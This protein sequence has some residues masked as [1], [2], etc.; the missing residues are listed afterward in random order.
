[1]KF[2][3]ILSLIST[4]AL[5]KN[6]ALLIGVGNFE[7][8]VT[9]D[10]MNINIDIQ[11][12]KEIVTAL[13]NYKIDTLIDSNAT[14]SRII[15]Y[16]KNYINSK[17][18]NKDSNFFLYFS[19]H[20]LQIKDENQDETDG[21]DEG[22]VLFD[23]KL[24]KPLLSK[25]II[26]KD[27]ILI[28][29]ELYSLLSQV[30][31]KKIVI[32]DK[33][34]ADTSD[35]GLKKPIIIKKFSGKFVLDKDFYKNSI[36]KTSIKN[37]IDSGIYKNYYILSAVKDKESATYNPR[38]GSFFTLSL[39][40]AIVKGKVNQNSTLEKL[41]KFSKQQMQEL[42]LKIKA[43]RYYTPSIRP[44]SSL[45][46]T[47]KEVFGTLSTQ[48]TTQSQ[49]LVEETLDMLSNNIL[50][51]DGYKN[52]YYLDH[53]IEFNIKSKK[54]GY[55]NIFISYPNRYELFIKNKKIEA[56]KLY[57]FPNSF[58]TKTL[59]A[60]LPKGNTKIYTILTKSKIDIDNYLNKNRK[61]DNLKTANL[62]RKELAYYCEPDKKNKQKNDAKEFN[63]IDIA[64]IE[65]KVK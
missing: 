62:I 36:D 22:F 3:L 38:L 23:A 43:P 54:S 33:C 8:R 63:I 52:S 28:D 35:R 56:D 57:I 30:K 50:T 48:Q 37:N 34:N 7:N 42:S 25:K 14:R 32:V 55:I 10:T 26:I 19:G 21:L 18:N 31:S 2:L 13:G 16:L 41:L 12:A 15:E 4:L 17:N 1:M 11:R 24:E 45:N 39:Y 6:I 44:Y 64:K 49:P 61:R 51:V 9:K 20:G 5:S 27:G 60:S 59:I 47:I 29:D 58:T 53:K 40:D 65:F 46:K